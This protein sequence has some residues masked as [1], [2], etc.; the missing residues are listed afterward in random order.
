MEN[1]M[2]IDIAGKGQVHGVNHPEIRDYGL[3]FPINVQ[4]E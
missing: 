2:L 4:E 3:E 1:R